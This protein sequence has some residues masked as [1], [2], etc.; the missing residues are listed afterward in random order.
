MSNVISRSAVRQAE[1]SGSAVTEVIVLW[2]QDVLHVAYVLPPKGF[3]VGEFQ[4]GQGACDFL[5]PKEVLGAS[6][7]P[8]VVPGARTSSIVIPPHATGHVELV[9]EAPMTLQAA[10]RRATPWAGMTGGF[11]LALPA[12]GKACLRLGDFTFLLSAVSASKPCK[13]GF[14]AAAEPAVLGFFGLSLAAAASF[15]A[16]MA[17]IAPPQNGLYDEVLAAD[18]VYL[19]QQYLRASAER[20]SEVQPP[21][22]VANVDPNNQEGSSGTRAKGEEGKLGTPNSQAKTARYA[23]Q[24]PSDNPD[25][26]VSRQQLLR[27]ASTGGMIGL[28]NTVAVSNPNAPTAPWGRDEALGT[29]EFSAR[30]NLWGDEIGQPY[31]A[32]GLGLSGTGQGGGG[33][34]DGIGL[35]SIGT[36]GHGA[37]TGTGQGFGVG[38]GSHKVRAPLICGCGDANVSGRLP[39]EVIQRIIRQNYGRFRSCYEQGLSR[40]PNL[41]GRVQVRFVVGRDGSVANV[42]RGDS[43][44]PDSGVVGC[45]VSAYYGLSFPRP[46]GG[47]VTVVY[48]I[49]FQPS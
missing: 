40:N 37:G 13:K 34:G 14:A 6:Q 32:N 43:D 26:H 33:L 19:I 45:V 17:Y 24:G 46:E 3:V 2:G 44:L 22:Q 1:I 36:I 5:M 42:Q 11:Q 35:A 16:A 48:P 15:M 41:E 27:E 20:E 18:Q 29:D 49:M 4:E 25:T 31:G 30:G 7:L 8:L 47:I 21:E 38:H 12:H 9:G 28:L 10:Q 23:I 39:P